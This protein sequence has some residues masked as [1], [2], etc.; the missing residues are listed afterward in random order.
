MKQE[1][2]LAVIRSLDLR[3]VHAEHVTYFK[4]IIP[5]FISN[6]DEEISKFLKRKKTKYINLKLSPPFL[7]DPIKLLFN[8]TVHQS[9][10]HFNQKDLEKTLKDLDIY[11]V[12]EPFFLYSGQVAKLAKKFNKPL[13]MAPF[14]CFNHPSTVIPPYSLSVKKS[15]NETDLFIMRSKK[16]NE[17][18]SRFNIPDN[19]KV[20]IY[21]G[22]NTKRF[23]PTNSKENEVVKI[24]FIGILHESKG[25]K[26][27]LDIFPNLVKESSKKIELVICC[28]GSMEERVKNMAKYLPIKFLGQVSNL[29]LPQVYRNADI[30][31]GPS[32]DWYTFGMIRWE[33]SFGFVLVEA[34]ASG[35][36]IVTNDC[37]AIKEIVGENNFINTQNDKKALKKSLLELI[38]NSTERLILGRKNR[39]RV[40]KMFDMEKQ[41]KKEE[42]EIIN[43]F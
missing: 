42:K 2:K 9:W 4:N 30:F 27:L 14:T 32:K 25:L 36:P 38:N 26:D 21:H 10:L 34:M 18:L 16:V 43:H 7:L 1:K 12:Q 11:Q 29:N 24:L 6:Y 39:L 13:I 28:S 5:T 17:Y 40:L 31:C 8:D 3:I 23:F 22:V 37:G 35:L 41:V 33:E 15:I 20:L 19:K